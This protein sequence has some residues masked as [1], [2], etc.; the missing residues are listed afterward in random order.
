M[1]LEHPHPAVKIQS[2]ITVRQF[3]KKEE[4]KPIFTNI[5]ATIVDKVLK[6]LEATEHEDLVNTLQ[7]F[8]SQ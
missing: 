5:V 3:I 2:A 4:S 8:V 1:N 7:E 6:T